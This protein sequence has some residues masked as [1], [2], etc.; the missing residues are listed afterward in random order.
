MSPS[1][2][3]TSRTVF[4]ASWRGSPDRSR[5][6]LASGSSRAGRSLRNGFLLK[7]PGPEN[8]RSTVSGHAHQLLPPGRHPSPFSLSLVDLSRSRWLDFGP[9]R[10][11]FESVILVL[12]CALHRNPRTSK[13]GG[14]T[15]WI[16]G[17]DESVWVW[18]E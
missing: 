3:T 10:I 13:S 7:S 17:W 14:N 5:A 16:C 15:H 1:Q 9:I 2:S 11:R 8:D 6:V 12:W 18:R 4:K